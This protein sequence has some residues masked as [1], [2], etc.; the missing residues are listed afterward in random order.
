MTTKE[1]RPLVE[2][3][4]DGLKRFLARP[5]RKPNNKQPPRFGTVRIER[6]AYAACKHENDDGEGNS[7]RNYRAVPR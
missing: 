7:A 3:D 1:R 4:A 6:R 5:K 2:P